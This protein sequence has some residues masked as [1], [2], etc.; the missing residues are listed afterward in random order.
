M[1]KVQPRIISAPKMS[2][3]KHR[4]RTFRLL[5][6]Q[7]INTTPGN[8]FYKVLFQDVHS[9]M[10]LVEDIFPEFLH[11]HYAIG[12]HYKDGRLDYRRP[13]VGETI[14]VSVNST[15]ENR[16]VPASDVL[17]D[18]EYKL[19]QWF[20]TPNGHL[21]FSKYNK[22]QYCL[23]AEESGNQ[24]II[25]C[26]VV[27]AR[28]YFTS[29]S[30]RRQL[31]SMKL[32][33]LYE[34]IKFD[35]TKGS[36]TL[37]LNSGASGE[38]AP[39]IARF[40]LDAFANERWHAVY[41][42]LLEQKRHMDIEGD[43]AHVAPLQI[44]FPVCQRIDMKVRGLR[45]PSAAGR[46]EKILVLE[47]L[48]ENSRFNFNTLTVRKKTRGKGTGKKAVVKVPQPAECNVTNKKPS[49]KARHHSIEVTSRIHTNPAY[50]RVR[51][52]KEF[53]TDPA[54]EG[55]DSCIPV[56]VIGEPSAAVSFIAGD[57]EGD[58]GTRQASVG[59]RLQASDH[60][61]EETK[62][63]GSEQKQEASAGTNINFTLEDFKEMSTFLM[64]SLD[65]DNFLMS[66][67]KRVP[68]KNTRRQREELALKES[69]D[70]SYDNKRQYITVT[71]N[72]AGKSVCLIEIDHDGLVAGPGTIYLIT[73]ESTSSPASY[74]KMV[75]DRFVY[76][77]THEETAKDLQKAGITFGTKIH[78]MAK[79]NPFYLRWAM[80]LLKKISPE[81]DGKWIDD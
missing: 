63:G 53:Y 74:A 39:L 9:R 5:W 61:S 51:T 41:K 27:G 73:D 13:P 1:P 16:F 62:S 78:P 11:S 24:I 58:S 22:R 29:S 68:V 28:F 3:D 49:S 72:Y 50:S 77:I 80:E 23:V 17:S 66:D 19:N 40:V 67:P 48:E 65:V 60:E 2:G 70:R 7:G 25:P 15:S 26:A 44:D 12:L 71:F 45:F 79:D 76:G 14:R 32:D 59:S 10:Y 43:M 47:I 37:L 52:L 46:G 6:I 30:M 35:S 18:A 34:D 31:F 64:W 42:S 20:P 38:D 21:D 75:A 33:G 56:P 54:K 8:N 81:Y 57:S 36:V 69:Y 4:H 55:K